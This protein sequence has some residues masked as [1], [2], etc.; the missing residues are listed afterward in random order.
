[1]RGLKDAIFKEMKERGHKCGSCED[2]AQ[3]TFMDPAGFDVSQV[4]R[5]RCTG[6]KAAS[7]HSNGSLTT[8]IILQP[9]LRTSTT[10][11]T[12]K[13]ASL[14][15]PMQAKL[16]GGGGS[17]TVYVIKRNVPGKGPTLCAAKLFRPDVVVNDEALSC[18]WREISLHLGLAYQ[19]PEVCQWLLEPLGWTTLVMKDHRYCKAQKKVLALVLDLADCC[20]EQYLE[21]VVSGSWSM[22][23]CWSGRV[24]MYVLLHLCW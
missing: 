4:R 20:M 23:P 21:Q 1:M 14:P 3:E 8:M 19:N 7:Q 5:A 9:T 15:S 16:L 22:Q 10:S 12:P 18:V 2:F 6:H 13:H 11:S 17:G 24:W